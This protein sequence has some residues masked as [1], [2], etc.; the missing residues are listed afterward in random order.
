MRTRE[1]KKLKYVDGSLVGVRVIGG[2]ANLYF[3]ANLIKYRLVM[4]WRSN[5]SGSGPL[6]QLGP[7]GV[8]EDPEGRRGGLMGEVDWSGETY[9]RQPR[10]VHGME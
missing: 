8:E 7:G 10:P 2:V 6:A 4:V 3:N 1:K 5:L 9:M